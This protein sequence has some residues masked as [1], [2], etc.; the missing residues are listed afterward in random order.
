VN[1]GLGI[2]KCLQRYLR[3][4]DSNGCRNSQGYSQRILVC[5]PLNRIGFSELGRV[6][7]G[8]LESEL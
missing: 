5:R 6:L 8:G 2:L 1:I 4:V 7:F 3:E